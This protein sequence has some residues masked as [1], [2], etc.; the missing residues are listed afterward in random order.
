VGTCRV[1]R[2]QVPFQ[3][4]RHRTRLETP[5]HRR[6]SIAVTNRRV[7]RV[8]LAELGLGS[9]RYNSLLA[10]FTREDAMAIAPHVTLYHNYHTE[11]R[12]AL[13]SP[14]PLTFFGAAIE[15]SRRLE[16]AVY[17]ICS[18]VGLSLLMGSSSRHQTIPQ[19]I[20]YS[21]IQISCQRRRS[22]SLALD[23]H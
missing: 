18:L 17:T 4:P 1:R 10:C 9:C 5:P 13:V 16:A 12:L 7:C 2:Y 8:C 14:E 11:V 6:S 23:R 20:H 19:G 3:R 21:M 22:S 15:P